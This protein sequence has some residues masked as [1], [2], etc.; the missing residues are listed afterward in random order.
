MG[1]QKV[2]KTWLGWATCDRTNSP[3]RLSLGD[4]FDLSRLG[5]LCYFGHE[6]ARVGGG[7]S[8]TSEE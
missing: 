2:E 7:V 8:E 3:L 5:V 6:F 4:F 1:C